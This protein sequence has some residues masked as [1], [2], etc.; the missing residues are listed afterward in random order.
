[1]IVLGMVLQIGYAEI[2]FKP[3][4]IYPDPIWGKYQCYVD[5]PYFE[6]K[7]GVKMTCSIYGET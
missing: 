6:N 2:I 3:Y 7:L 4:I 5:K 1:M